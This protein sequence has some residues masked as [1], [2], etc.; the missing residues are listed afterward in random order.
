MSQ[1][2]K[3][4]KW[5]DQLN[6]GL[7]VPLKYL[8]SNSDYVLCIYCEKSFLG[9]QKSQL[10]QHLGS[11]LHKT[12]KE[13]KKK[14]KAHQATLEETLG[15]RKKHP[16]EIM[17]QE[18]CQAL[19]SAGI[20]LAKMKNKH[21]HDFLEKYTGKTIPTEAHL[22]NKYVPICYDE[23]LSRMREELKEGS[24]WVVAD[25]ARDAQGR[26]VANVVIGKLDHNE[27]HK[28]F[29]VKMA[30]L[31]TGDSGTMSRLINDTLR[32]L[33]PNFDCNRLRIFVS[34]AAPYMC[35]CGRDLKVFFPCLIH[36]TCVV[37][38][39]SLVTEKAIEVFPEV[40]HLIATCKMVFVKAPACRAAYHESCP[41]LALPPEP[42]LTR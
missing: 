3:R 10:T 41:G 29:L 31:E 16:A 32:L 9:G 34:D 14:R 27:F 8:S 30:F 26:E 13:L 7:D 21:L 11:E 23:V 4:A 42:V 24:L 28:P 37:H 6:D 12:N 2:A 15:A 20:P 19:L 35:K 40:N 5:L 36:I 33:D 1:E 39:I 18:L 17:N 22:R 25:C 38:G